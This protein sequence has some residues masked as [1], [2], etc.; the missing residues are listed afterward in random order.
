[1]VG[2]ITIPR[3]ISQETYLKISAILAIV[4]T[5]VAYLT[6]GYLSVDFVA[7]L[8]FTNAMMLPA[9]FPLGIRALGRFTEVGS[10]IM[11]M[12]IAGGAVIPQLFAI[13]KQHFDFQWVFLLLMVPCYLYIWYFA[14]IGH[15]AGL[16]K[17]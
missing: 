14:K 12:G 9:I 7:L 4:F 1:V 15:R 17:A 16:P 6:T 5:V 8:C 3:F 2:L 13:L 10:A 11:I